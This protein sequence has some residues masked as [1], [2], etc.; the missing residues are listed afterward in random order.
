MSVEQ[1]TNALC[2]TVLATI[3]AEQRARKM[4]T[5]IGLATAISKQLMSEFTIIYQKEQE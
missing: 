4:L 5:Q 1:D 3:Q 2:S